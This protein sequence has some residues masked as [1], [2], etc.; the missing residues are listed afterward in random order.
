MVPGKLTL[1]EYQELI[2][3]L[4]AKRGFDSETIA[5]KFTLLMEECGE[6][7]KAARKVAQISTHQKHNS[8]D[9]EEE[10]AD[11]FWVLIDLCNNLGVDLE[12]AFEKKEK[13]H[14]KRK[15]S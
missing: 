9:I 12:E 6:L 3:R 10:A 13:L 14:Q 5:Q 11:V 8:F 15:W 1:S 2:K 4:A 7:A